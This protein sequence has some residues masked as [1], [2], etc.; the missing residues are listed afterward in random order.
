[1]HRRVGAKRAACRPYLLATARR[2]RAGRAPDACCP[3]DARTRPFTP[4]LV[5]YRSSSSAVA[6][7]REEI[8]SMHRRVGAKRA[9]CRPYLLATARRPHA[10]RTPPTRHVRRPST[11]RPDAARTSEFSG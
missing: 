9:A 2:P 11:V 4:I 3:H 8:R 1:M 5:R 7:A 10:D 6:C